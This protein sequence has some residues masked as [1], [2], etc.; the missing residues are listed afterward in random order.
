VNK[1]TP[2]I[3]FRQLL[4]LTTHYW[5]INDEKPKSKTSG[6]KACNSGIKCPDYSLAEKQPFNIFCVGIRKLIIFEIVYRNYY[7]NKI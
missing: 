2:I 3:K 4:I 5:F 6:K 1:I 7:P